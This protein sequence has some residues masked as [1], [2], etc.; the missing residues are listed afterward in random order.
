V[1]LARSVAVALLFA[2][3]SAPAAWQRWLGGDT[4]G[5][6]ATT[7]AL[8][9]IAA[10]L[11]LSWRNEH[12]GDIL[13]PGSSVKTTSR[14]LHIST[15]LVT[16]GAASLIF[17][18]CRDWLHQILTFPVD[19]Y[20]GDMLVLIREGLRRMGGG[21]N[22]YTIHHVPWPAA[23]SYGPML[24]GP[25]ALPMLLRVDLRILAVAGELF[26]PVA[27]AAA[28]I[29][30]A[31]SGR[32]AAAAG[33][34][35]MLGAIALNGSLEAFTPSAHTPVYWPLVALFAWLTAR[36][37][38]PA[39]AIA[40]GL[41]VVARSTMIAIVPVL[42]MTVWL[43]NRRA[44]A[45]VCAL[46]AL[47]IALPFLPFAIWDL[48]ALV[49]ALYGAYETVIK[50]VV[51]PDTTVPHTI[52]LT[53]VLLTHHLQRFVEAVQVAVMSIV[54]VTSW[55]LLRRGRAPVA[56]MGIALLAFSMTTLWPVSYIY[57]DVF[58]LFAAG[59]LADMPW[60]DARVSTSSLVR[61]WTAVLVA[62]VILVAGFGAAM[63]Q[64]REFDRPIVTWRDGPR[65]ATVALIRRSISPA[66]V[67]VQIGAGHALPQRMGVALNGRSLGE[68]DVFAGA[69]HVL[70]PVPE[71]PW[72]IGA[73]TL[74]LSPTMP[75][76][77]REV[78]VRPTRSTNLT[79]P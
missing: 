77:F 30:S 63:L 71:S 47:V 9:V 4:A 79:R 74:E 46:V 17:V 56:L 40:L 14:R 27:C 2:L 45:G 52:G 22:P 61:R 5:Y 62:V 32:L 54:Y 6:I 68:V 66:I 28:A 72:Q 7:I 57:F 31:A 51:W 43:R 39:A 58:L 41:L 53:G 20:R 13:A 16:L 8:A 25:Y 78:I 65:L 76:T 44:F 11:V 29:A 23:L 59:V 12:H 50:A 18:A 34:L 3:L 48:R 67:D 64:L 35:V 75:V 49:Y 19:S 55:I 36:E 15:V 69:D 33:A 38:W 37:R 24:W 1:L 42:L 21:L 10:A 70:L 26:V 60:L 73:N